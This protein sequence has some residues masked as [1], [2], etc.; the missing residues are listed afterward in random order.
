MRAEIRTIL[1]S[2]N[3]RRVARHRIGQNL[4]PGQGAPDANERAGSD[5][6]ATKTAN[7]KSRRVVQ[8]LISE[9]ARSRPRAAR[10][11]RFTSSP[12]CSEQEAFLVSHFDPTAVRAIPVEDISA[13]MVV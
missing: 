4:H 5:G 3:L 8:M 7:M 11:P 6:I 13:P 12:E 10:P 2:S 1:V 9:G